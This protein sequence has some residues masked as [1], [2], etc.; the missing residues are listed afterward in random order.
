VAD[1][2]RED[3]KPFW[4]LVDMLADGIAWL[5]AIEPPGA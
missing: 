5:P 3:G 2:W 4:C 1:E